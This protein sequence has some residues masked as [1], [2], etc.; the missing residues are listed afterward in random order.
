MQQENLTNAITVIGAGSWG[1]ALAIHLARKNYPVFLY[2][3]HQDTLDAMRET[4]ENKRHIPGVI[5]P[6][7]LKVCD[8]WE[9]VRIDTDNVLLAVPSLFFRSTLTHLKFRLTRPTRIIWGTKG[10]DS[11]SREFLSAVAKEVLGD[12]H[13]YAV[14]SGP[15]FA[16]EVAN[17]LP[18]AVV[19]ASSEPAIAEYFADY[20]ASRTFRAYLSHDMTGVQLCGAVKNIMAIAVGI[21]DGLGFGANAR[22]ALITRGLAEMRRLGLALGAKPE[23]FLGLAGV[24]DLVLTCTDNQSRNRRLGLA[25]GQGI[26]KTEASLA[27]AESVEGVYAA[28]CVWQ[29]ARAHAIEMPIADCVYRILN[30]GVAPLSAVEMLLSRQTGFE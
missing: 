2:S 25:L 22:S 27:I 28:E 24:G 8:D 26:S 4:R 29:I 21:S 19:I 18:T 6:P 20:F 11:H 12:T 16:K 5:F 10:F 14:L 9:R 3:R 15:S 30:E 13:H 23:T 17:A 1:T 7:S